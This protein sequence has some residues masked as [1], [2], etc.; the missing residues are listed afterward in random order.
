MS[1][2]EGI[3]SRRRM[4]EIAATLCGLTVSGAPP[5]S[6]QEVKRRRT[7]NE[8]VGPFYPVVKPLDQD[9]DLTL[10]AGKQGRAEGKIIHLT[11]RVLNTRGEPVRGARVEIW[12]A[13][14]FGRYAHQSDHNPAPLDPNF[15][16]YGVQVTDEEGRYRF[17]TVKPGAYPVDPKNPT[18]IRPPH[19]HFDVSGKTDRLV[20]QMYFEREALNDKDLLLR[21]LEVRAKKESVIARV[22]PPTND[23]EPDSSLVPWDI[24]L[25]NG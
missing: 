23:L 17:K 25:E 7:P 11:G 14:T 4:L 15:Q 10:V 16:G 24:F 13:N 18:W 5:L 9:A 8:I 1:E 20:T 3:I 6:A 21:G 12:Q 22:L 2:R 19:I